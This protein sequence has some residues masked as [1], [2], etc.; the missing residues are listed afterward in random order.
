MAFLALAGLVACNGASDD[1]PADADDTGTRVGDDDDT[2]PPLGDDEGS[3]VVLSW[4]P[5]AADPDP[6]TIFAAMFAE[7]RLGVQNLAQCI[8]SIDAFC[9]DRLPQKPGDSVVVTGLDPA[10]PSQ[11][12]TVDVGDTLSLGPWS[13]PYEVQGGTGL[14]FYFAPYADV[15]LPT[16]PVGLTLGDGDW[17]PYAGT[18]DVVPPTPMDVTSHDPLDDVDF[19]DTEPVGLEWTPGTDGEVYLLVSSPVEQ[20]LYRL[21]DDGQHDLDLAPLGLGE[22]DAVEVVLGR[23]SHATLDL[24]G[25]EAD[26]LIE[27]NQRLAGTFRALGPRVELTAFYDTCPEAEPAP[28]VAPGSYYGDFTSFGSH[29]NPGPNGCTGFPAAGRDAIV[30][31]DL[32]PD[33]LLEV[34]YELPV[35]DASL[36]LLTDCDREQT[37]VAG[38]DSTLVSGVEKVSYLNGSGADQRVYVVLDAFDQVTDPFDLDIVVTS[39]GTDILKPTCLE[40]QDQGPI[41]SGEYHGDIGGNA[42][43]LDPEC[44]AGAAG[45]EGLAEVYLLGGQTLTAT[46]TASGGVDPE[47]YL[48]SN[49]S[50]ADSCVLG[51]DVLSGSTETLVYTNP[52]PA[53]A[54]VYLVVDGELNVNEYFLDVAIQ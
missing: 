16:A 5:S 36:Y 12:D 24:G 52:G 48:M 31:I 44:A 1:A 27:S 21:D 18:A 35:D 4:L 11:L 19:Y 54:H 49:C 2:V 39:L 15:D 42:D 32:L 7:S 38:S 9:F 50:I 6:E 34:T 10:I 23:W 8:S 20:R 46:V 33:E 40:A 14:G 37:C 26:L 41:A 25:N 13:A 45:G 43:L 47:M 28:G 17:G 51:V 3:V 29:H 22:G 30:P 53:S